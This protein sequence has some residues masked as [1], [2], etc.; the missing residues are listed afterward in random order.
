MRRDAE[1]LAGY[2]AADAVNLSGVVHVVLEELLGGSM[3]E[4]QRYFADPSG[5]LS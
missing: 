5:T 1:A 2:H 3:Q 4:A